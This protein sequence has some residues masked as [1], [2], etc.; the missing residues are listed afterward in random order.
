MNNTQK[1]HIKVK[2][3]VMIAL[4]VALTYLTNFLCNFKLGFLSFEAKDAVT[5]VCAYAFGPLS[6]I[7]V[8]LLSAVL[9]SMSAS[10]TGI[11][12]FVMNFVGSATYVGVAS[13]IYKMKKNI[14]FAVLGTILATVLMTS[15]MIGMNL[16]L[17]PFYMGV[18]TKAVI[19]LVIPLLLPFNIVKGIFNSCIVLIISYPI[20]KAMQAAGALDEPVAKDNAKIRNIVLSISAL[21]AVFVVMYFM[22]VLNGRVELFK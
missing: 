2:K 19:D 14:S 11:Y 21:L 7:I 18:E 6:G 5:T 17:T 20:L 22:V 13:I 1:N 10:A 12:G 8:A 9:E 3:M 4:F 16:I 15:V